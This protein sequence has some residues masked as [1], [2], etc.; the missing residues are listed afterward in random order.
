[1]NREFEFLKI[2][3]DTTHCEFLG[4]D[5]AYL[6]EYNLAISQDTLVEDVHFS[7]KYMS[8]FEIAQKSLLVNI[9]D[10]L[11]SGA[12]AQYFSIG[13][14]GN[15]DKKFIKEFYEG[16]NSISEQYNI[17]LIGGDLT[18]SDK[19]TISITI[20]GNYKNRKISYRKNAKKGY[21]VAAAGEFGSSAQGLYDLEHNIKDNYF[22]QIH[23]KPNLF[24]DISTQ[25]ALNSS[26]P[27]AMMDSSDGLFDCLY[28]ISS[29][30]KVRIDIDY[31]KI[32]HKTDNKDF[33]LYG[34]EDYC[35]VIALHQDDFNKIK[36]LIKIGTVSDGNGVYID[37][38]LTEYKSYQHFN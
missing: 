5:C 16:L 30:S 20:L 22:I 1:M 23:K 7:L 34:G 35:L 6:D 17:K 31:S 29:K 8:P 2:I 18:K 10:I 13:L 14:S 12:E 38:K 32:P 15:L 25:I 19:I 21:I 4:N 11:S 27:Y 24:P 28:Q 9:S 26:F 36:G 33:V 3:A 37:N